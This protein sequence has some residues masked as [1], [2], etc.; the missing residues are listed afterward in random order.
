M[1]FTKK[2]I[3][4]VFEKDFIQLSA[5]RHVVS[6]FVVVKLEEN[7]FLVLSYQ[8]INFINIILYIGNFEYFI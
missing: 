5:R 6:I 8:I 1:V 3:R 7:I 2:N 4:F